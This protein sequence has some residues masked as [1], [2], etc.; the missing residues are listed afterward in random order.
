MT[1]QDNSQIVAPTNNYIRKQL[2]LLREQKEGMSA[3]LALKVADI[4]KDPSLPD[5]SM[6]NINLYCSLFEDGRMHISENRE[7]G[8]ILLKSSSGF[9]RDRCIAAYI[10]SIRDDKEAL[11]KF[12]DI[13]KSYP[14]SDSYSNYVER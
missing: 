1:N 2:L 12:N 8:N 3:D 14:Y 13:I 10:I 5:L 6:D 7:A 9:M 4:I 11:S